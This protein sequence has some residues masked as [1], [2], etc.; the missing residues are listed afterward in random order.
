MN[1]KPKAV[2]FRVDL[3]RLGRVIQLFEHLARA[4]APAFVLDAN[5]SRR[6]VVSLEKV[7]GVEVGGEIGCDKLLVLTAGLVEEWR[8]AVYHSEDME[9]ER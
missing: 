5:V 9:H 7:G 4:D 1:V 2:G 3:I 8:L 6:M